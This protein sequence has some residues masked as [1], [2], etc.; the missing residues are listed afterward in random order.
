MTTCVQPRG[1]EHGER[2]YVRHGES[3]SCYAVPKDLFPSQ[4]YPWR[5]MPNILMTRAPL[6]TMTF[7]TEAQAMNLM[8][9]L[10]YGDYTGS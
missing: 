4:Q 10:Y 2:V 8:D 5:D 1:N 7:A 6:F 9:D 3:V